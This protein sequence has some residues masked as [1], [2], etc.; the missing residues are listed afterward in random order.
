MAV[1]TSAKCYY[2]YFHAFIN[3]LS[4]AICSIFVLKQLKFENIILFNLT[5]YLQFVC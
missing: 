4:D 2:H 5:M 3:I 1:P